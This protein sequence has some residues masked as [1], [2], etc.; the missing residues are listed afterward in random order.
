MHKLFIMSGFNAVSVYERDGIAGVDIGQPDDM[1]LH[2]YVFNTKPDL[3]E[4]LRLLSDAVIPE[5]FAIITE[6]EYNLLNNQNPN[7][8]DSK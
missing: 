3:D 5:A 2:A 1:T 6:D 4:A 7:S 8:N